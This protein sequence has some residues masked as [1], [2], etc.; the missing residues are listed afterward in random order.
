[1]RSGY[2][3]TP[4]V[5]RVIAAYWGISFGD[6]LMRS[7]HVDIVIDAATAAKDLQ[8]ALDTLVQ[9]ILEREDFEKVVIDSMHSAHTDLGIDERQRVYDFDETSQSWRRGSTYPWHYDQRYGI[10]YWMTG[11]IGYEGYWDLDMPSD[12]IPE[13]LIDEDERWSFIEKLFIY[14]IEMIFDRIIQGELE[15]PTV[16]V[17]TDEDLPSRPPG[18]LIWP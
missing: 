12:V 18:A 4:P 5:R 9:E 10:E 2:H 11:D 1:M 8:E 16:C 6:Y 3:E 15:I 17:L 13:W 14:K 7:T